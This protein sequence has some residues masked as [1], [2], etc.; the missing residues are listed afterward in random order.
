MPHD[1]KVTLTFALSDETSQDVSFEVPAGLDG[2]SAY[3]IWRNAQ[4]PTVLDTSEEA[5]LL[6]MKGQTQ[7]ALDLTTDKSLKGK[8]TEST[9][10]QVAVSAKPENQLSLAADGLLVQAKEMRMVTASGNFSFGYPDDLK[11]EQ[12]CGVF[13]NGVYWKTNLATTSIPANIIQI[14]LDVMLPWIPCDIKGNIVPHKIHT[15]A[16]RIVSGKRTMPV[17]LI[18]Y[19][20]PTHMVELTTRKIVR[21]ERTSDNITSGLLDYPVVDQ[22][23][24]GSVPRYVF[25]AFYSA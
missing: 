22:Q 6:Y 18:C 21:L 17:Y 15:E 9:P 1:Q 5:Y 8:G 23:V 11:A 16:P 4:P 13:G 19:E 14:M 3:E 25:R 12:A 10:L 7:E 24:I 2:L 20:R